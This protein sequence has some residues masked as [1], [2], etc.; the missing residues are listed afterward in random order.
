MVEIYLYTYQME[1]DTTPL[2]RRHQ[3][4]YR[5][6][7]LASCCTEQARSILGAETITPRTHKTFC[8][9]HDIITAPVTNKTGH[10]FTV[11]V[12][13]QCQ[14][15]LVTEWECAG[16]R[17]KELNNPTCCYAVPFFFTVF[18]TPRLITVSC[19]SLYAGQFTDACHMIPKRRNS[20]QYP[21]SN[22]GV[23]N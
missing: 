9:D 13:K 19:F 17:C 18:V 6:I 11:T 23:E 14:W 2:I 4:L 5:F 1:L 22:I 15:I 8:N 12:A 7:N 10:V 3:L 20:I 16:S 21:F